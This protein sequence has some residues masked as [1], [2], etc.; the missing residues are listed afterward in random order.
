MARHDLGGLARLLAA[1]WLALVVLA[2]CERADGGG[3][4]GQATRGRMVQT[5]ST[6]VAP[7]APV[8]TRPA[9]AR[10]AR[11]SRVVDGDTVE[12]QVDGRRERVRYVGINTPES[13]DPNRPVECY[14]KEAAARNRELVEGRTVWLE[15]DTSDTDQY[16][17]LLR[18]VWL[19]GPGGAILVNEALVRDG[20]AY[21]RT[22][23]PDTARQA[24]L[25]AAQEAARRER[26]G[27]WGACPAR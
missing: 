22:Y 14:G 8:A 20:Y 10:E 6:T 18:Y 13:A 23:R 11:V 25:D 24:Q 16:G 4:V 17:R 9:T 1:V 2:G 19:D 7:A 5:G 12:A 27:L 3:R 15:R 26:R 21:A